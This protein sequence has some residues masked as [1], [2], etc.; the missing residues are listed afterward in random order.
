MKSE[1]NKSRKTNVRRGWRN[2]RKADESFPR[3]WR[4]KK[5]VDESLQREITDLHFTVSSAF[6]KIEDTIYDAQDAVG[7]SNLDQPT[8]TELLKKF[9]TVWRSLREIV[10]VIGDKGLVR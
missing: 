4:P 2:K 6:D 9:Q 1:N 3:V 8:K 10:N 7:Y 5:K